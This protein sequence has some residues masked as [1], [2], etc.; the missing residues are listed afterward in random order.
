MQKLID[1][2]NVTHAEVYEAAMRDGAMA[3]RVLVRT[4][5]VLDP[6]S[7]RFDQQSYAALMAAIQD[8]MDRRPDITAAD[9]EGN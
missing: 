2:P 4:D 7:D 3:T 9:I 1:H 5:L 8:L 6:D